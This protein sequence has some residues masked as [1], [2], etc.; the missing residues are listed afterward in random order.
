MHKFIILMLVLLLGVSFMFAQD[1]IIMRI[2]IWKQSM[3]V[4]TRK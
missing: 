1:T 3:R 4:R 2:R